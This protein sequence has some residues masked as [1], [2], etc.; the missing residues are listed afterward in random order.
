MFYYYV[1]TTTNCSRN[2]TK[3]QTMLVVV[4][5]DNQSREHFLVSKNLLGKVDQVDQSCRQQAW[6]WKAGWEEKAKVGD[7]RDLGSKKSKKTAAHLQPGV[8]EGRGRAEHR[9]GPAREVAHAQHQPSHLGHQGLR[10]PSSSPGGE[11]G[12]AECHVLFYFLYIVL[13]R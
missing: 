12:Q 8:E 5:L 2:E 10:L 11:K 1:L 7:S 3:L 13:D 4:A 9:G 6:T